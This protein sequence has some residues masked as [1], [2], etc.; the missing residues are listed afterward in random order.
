MMKKGPENVDPLKLEHLNY[1]E[2]SNNS[3]Y[4][5]DCLIYLIF[6]SILRR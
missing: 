5:F 4:E 3:K 6:K 2:K 1:F